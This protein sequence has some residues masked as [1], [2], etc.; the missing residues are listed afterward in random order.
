MIN[1]KQIR[2]FLRLPPVLRCLYLIFALLLLGGCD[3]GLNLAESRQEAD[4]VICPPG[5]FPPELKRRIEG[6]CKKACSFTFS[7]TSST[8]LVVCYGRQEYAG[9]SIRVEECSMGPRTLYLRT[10]LMGPGG[11]DPVVREPTWPY[12]VVRCQRTDKVCR[13]ER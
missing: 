7:N 4:Y 2:Y 3:G 9:C 6:K 5:H 10:Q 13:I 12:I 1:N 11:E 8:Y